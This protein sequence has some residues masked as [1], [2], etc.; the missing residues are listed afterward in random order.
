[1]LGMPRTSGGGRLWVSGT[2]S[3]SCTEGYGG[4][5]TEW[6][7]WGDAVRCNSESMDEEALS[8]MSGILMMSGIEGSELSRG[9]SGA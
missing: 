6:Q 9:D 7:S 3:R 8:M 2:L 1:M 5:D 4:V